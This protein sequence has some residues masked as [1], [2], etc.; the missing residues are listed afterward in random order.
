VRRSLFA[1]RREAP[2]GEG[3]AARAN[4]ISQP[5]RR[6]RSER[7][8]WYPPPSGGGRGAVAPRPCGAGGGE[9]R[10][11]RSPLAGVG[12]RLGRA[13]DPL[14]LDTANDGECVDRQGAGEAGRHVLR[15]IG[16]SW[17]R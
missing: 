17:E 10:G 12:V 14:G 4:K 7:H 9:M 3:R 6:S 15:S 13:N 16:T 2:S 1:S 5:V 11:I 8:A